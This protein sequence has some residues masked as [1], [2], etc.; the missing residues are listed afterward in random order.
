ML[1]LTLTQ[2]PSHQ[3]SLLASSVNPFYC[4]MHCMYSASTALI[5]YVIRLSVCPSV[6]DVDVPWAYVLG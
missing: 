1:L 2:T 6:C 5:S 4:A 3:I